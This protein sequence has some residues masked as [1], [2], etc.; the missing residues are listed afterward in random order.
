M[1]TVLVVDDEP[2][3]VQFVCAALED[4]GFT[5]T[6]AADGRQ[7]LEQAVQSPPDL[8]VLDM[9][10]PV[11]GGEGV[12]SEIRRLHG[13]VPILL[14]TADGRAQ[15]KA[16]RVGAFDYLTKPFDVQRLLTLVLRRLQ[17]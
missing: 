10:L 15:E 7:A 3:I 6:T 12:A 8:V 4:E 11:V 9:M 16:G 13:N 1:A 2:E 5:V 17:P 14:M